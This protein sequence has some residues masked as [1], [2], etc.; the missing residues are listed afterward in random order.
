MA[1]G[2]KDEKLM[3]CDERLRKQFEGVADDELE[4]LGFP[5][6]CKTKAV[7]TMERVCEI[8]KNQREIKTLYCQLGLRMARLSAMDNDKKRTNSSAAAA[9]A[10]PAGNSSGTS[11]TSPGTVNPN[12]VPVLLKKPT[13]HSSFPSAKTM[14]REEEQCPSNHEGNPDKTISTTD[15]TSKSITVSSDVCNVVK[16]STET[17]APSAPVISRTD[18]QCITIEDEQSNEKQPRGTTD[19]TRG[20]DL[21]REKGGLGT[22]IH[23]GVDEDTDER[24]IQ[25]ENYNTHEN[26]PDGEN[27]IVTEAGEEQ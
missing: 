8:D 7:K 10:A 5:S 1:D 20:V 15:L 25:E 16:T 23:S 24:T 13:I 27:E 17:V 9:A 12:D 6:I 18:V 26:H 19:D 3:G 21:G 2:G 11:R 14:K 4:R 22:A